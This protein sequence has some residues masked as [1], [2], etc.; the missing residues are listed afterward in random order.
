MAHSNVLRKLA[1]VATLA[2][3]GGALYGGKVVAAFRHD[4]LSGQTAS[5]KRQVLYWYDTMDP[6]HHYQK[7]GKAPD[8]MDLAPSYADD[9]AT[10]ATA[11]GA[12]DA[13]STQ[14]AATAERKILYWY[15]PMHPQYK[16]DKPGKAPDCGMDLVPKY[17]EEFSTSNLAPGSV[18]IPYRQ[19]TAH[20]SADRA[21]G[22][23][24]AGARSEHQRSDHRG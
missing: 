10:P 1:L 21:R 2:V 3:A 18:M 7:P 22:T 23:G 5:G 20:R 19:A 9:A 4:R 12:G 24:I 13:A 11:N 17:A 8:G 14:S 6:Q 15:D 16:A